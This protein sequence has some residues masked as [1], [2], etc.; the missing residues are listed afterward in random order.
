MLCM[1]FSQMKIMPTHVIGPTTF[2]AQ[3][4]EASQGNELLEMSENLQIVCPSANSLLVSPSMNK[5]V[6][7]LMYM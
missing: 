2:W 5:V 4:I 3:S 7:F 1:N 6:H